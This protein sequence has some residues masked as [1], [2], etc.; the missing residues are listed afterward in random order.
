MKN[1]KVKYEF[2][3]YTEGLIN[4]A[5]RIANRESKRKFVLQPEEALI[6]VL[7]DYIE[8]KDNEGKR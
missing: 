7:E 1:K 4:I 8:I 6:A 5:C 2:S 3:Q